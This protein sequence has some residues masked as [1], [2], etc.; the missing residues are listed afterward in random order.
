MDEATAL[1]INLLTR[2]S[3]E[4]EI[5]QRHKVLFVIDTGA[6]RTVI[7]TQLAQTLGLTPGPPALVHGVTSDDLAETVRIQTMKLG[8]E[9]FESILAPT[10]PRASLGADGLIGLDLIG[11]FQLRIDFRN[12]SV[13]LQPF[14]DSIV[15]VNRPEA[16][17]GRVGRSTL[18]AVK[19][20]FGQLLLPTQVGRIQVDAFVDSGSQYSIG[21]LALLRA[22]GTTGAAY[23]PLTR[24]RIVGVNGAILEAEI[25]VVPS[26]RLARRDM[27]P[28]SLFFADLNVFEAMGL[29]D[30]P[31]L[32]LG[33]DL[34]TRFDSVVLDFA[35]SRVALGRR[36]R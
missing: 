7:S 1:S 8:G 33:A 25:G 31:A 12:Q 13:V 18:R 5:D 19:G 4:V 14:G 11:Q 36:R 27:G 28:T 9:R 30:R 3:A 2:M 34:I 6:E 17:A 26:L 24:P 21:N 15:T 35:Q 29:K 16:L 22:A 10:F 23:V 32:L 20:R